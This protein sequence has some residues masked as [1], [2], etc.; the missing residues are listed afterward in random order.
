MLLNKLTVAGDGDIFTL[1][2][3]VHAPRVVFTVGD[4]SFCPV[5]SNIIEPYRQSIV[6]VD[7]VSVNLANVVDVA[8]FP[9]DVSEQKQLRV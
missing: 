7:S 3:V 6:A 4:V 9:S 8:N 5:A 1:C 2:T